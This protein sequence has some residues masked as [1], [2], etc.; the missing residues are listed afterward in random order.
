MADTPTVNT[1]SA[2]YEAQACRWKLI[3]LILSGVKAV[4]ESC[5]DGASSAGI[6]RRERGEDNLEFQRRRDQSRLVDFLGDMIED[7]AGRLFRRHPPFDDE[8][9]PE[10]RGPTTLK[11]AKPNRKPS[12]SAGWAENID[13]QG[14]HLQVFGK[15]LF[16][17]AKRHG[18]ACIYID[19]PPKPESERTEEDAKRNARRPYWILVTAPQLIE[20]TPRTVNGVTRLAQARI[21]ET[22]LVKASRWDPGKTVNRVR[23]LVDG[24]AD[25]E[26]TREN[27]GV[28]ADHP[29]FAD[30][31]DSARRNL[32][33]E[34]TDAR[35]LV[36]WELHE[37]REV[38]GTS[39]KQWVVIDSGTFASPRFIPLVPLSLDP[40]A[41]FF[42]AI[43]PRETTALAETTAEYFAMKSPKDSFIRT[44]L[45]AALHWAGGPA[46]DP[47][48]AEGKGHVNPGRFNEQSFFVSPDVGAHMEFVEPEGTSLKLAMENLREIEARARQQSMEPLM[49]GT[50]DITATDAALRN[51][52][53]NSRLEAQFVA[54]VDCIER[55]MG[56]TMMVA[57]TTAGEDVG[58]SLVVDLEKMQLVSVGD[59]FTSVLE[60]AKNRII[61]PKT[62]VKEAVRYKVLGEDTDIDVV[63]Q[64]V[65]QETPPGLEGTD[66]V[67]E[68][69]ALKA[70]LE[71]MEGGGVPRQGG[72]IED[73]ERK[74][75]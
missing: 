3:D 53:A 55:A 63:R 1:P 50:G 38:A 74:V 26:A 60:L 59:N 37:E 20:A 72:T 52:K 57:K 75:A 17:A 33:L 42:E 40:E 2:A 43:P 68:I 11:G 65:E 54:Y 35:R 15:K 29:R 71:A 22:A 67:S 19:M 9:P 34:A 56:V 5:G 46:P 39:E 49:P 25:A 51:S 27:P 58:G 18:L 47:V 44:T 23:V 10:M 28:A 32:V 64:E 24:L 48:Q 7:H 6:L 12:G 41:G 36:T 16:K 31:A 8:V 70:R 62:A 45:T 73:V 13:L 30:M 4:R 61:G 21:R 66:P 69:E 14:N